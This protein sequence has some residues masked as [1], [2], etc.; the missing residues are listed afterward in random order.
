MTDRE[1]LV[2]PACGRAEPATER[3]ACPECG[4]DRTYLHDSPALPDATSEADVELDADE[5]A[6]GSGSD[7]RDG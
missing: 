5:A 4:S 2:C 1:Y 7:D 6:G 3:A